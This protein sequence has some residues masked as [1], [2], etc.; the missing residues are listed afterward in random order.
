MKR[1]LKLK[2]FLALLGTAALAFLLSL[3]LG[4]AA[5]EGAQP[6]VLD[7]R[8]ENAAEQLVP[9]FVQT[10]TDGL[11]EELSSHWKIDRGQ[12]TISR[13]NDVDISPDIDLLS[14]NANL[15]FKNCS[16]RFFE[17]NF[18]MRLDP[19][20]GKTEFGGLHG[21]S[22]VLFGS[23]NMAHRFMQS[24][25]GLFVMPDYKVE[26]Y[27]ST[28]SSAIVGD[29]VEMYKGSDG[30]VDYQVR[31]TADGEEGS[32]GHIV[33]RAG[34][35][36]V[37]DAY[38]PAELIRT[39][40]IGLFTANS[41][42]T[43][44]DIELYALNA[45]GD[46]IPSPKTTLVSGVEMVDKEIDLF[47]GEEGRRLETT[48]RPA[49]ADN[50]ALTYICSDPDVLAVD[51]EGK[52]FPLREGE[53]KVYAVSV[54]GGFT[55][56]CTVRIV[57]SVPDLEGV[58]LSHTEISGKVGEQFALEAFISPE[59]AENDGFRWSSSDFN[60]AMVSNGRV[61]FVGEGTCTI[62]VKDY[63]GRFSASCTV[64]VTSAEKAGGCKS[65][66]TVSGSAGALLFVSAAVV[67]AIK[68]R[69]RN[70]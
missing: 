50:K 13:I 66:L 46:K 7:F 10:A 43:F 39:G 36:A 60:V 25:N 30:F 42:A 14:R 27:G 69:N 61:S 33:V 17:M 9:Y 34:G 65:F 18:S 6:Y 1:G 35:A 41:L 54:D 5:E 16:Y 70:A 64:V 40:R 20:E 28:V 62:T 44:R 23:N 48:V 67:F 53:T 49:Q 2:K 68:G 3:P 38:F 52:M 56:E 47:M 32:E 63:E 4:A 24:G 19:V 26:L 29:S 58:S 51:N 12:G 22:G 59:D 57:S 45:A 37:L 11:S 55:A 8:N 15:F 31:I 21:V